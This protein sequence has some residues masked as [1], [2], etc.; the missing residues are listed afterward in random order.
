MEHNDNDWSLYFVFT[1]K[2]LNDVNVS[3]GQVWKTNL[4]IAT[5]WLISGTAGRFSCSHSVREWTVIAVQLKECESERP[6]CRLSGDHNCVDNQNE[7][8]KNSDTLFNHTEFCYSL[9]T[10]RSLLKNYSSE[11]H[12][13]VNHRNVRTPKSL[14]TKQL[15]R[16]LEWL[17]IESQNIWS[18]FHLHQNLFFWKTESYHLIMTAQS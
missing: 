14:D 10:W 15:E 12:L 9:F 17:N 1:P 8:K 3:K 2:Q 7:T 4:P 5:C 18:K 6:S 13:L 16:W 11:S